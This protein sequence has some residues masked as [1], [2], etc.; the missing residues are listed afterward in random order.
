MNFLVWMGNH[1][2]TGQRSLE[3]VIGIFGH[4][5]R[6]LG[7]QIIWD[8]RNHQFLTAER[9]INIV[10]EGFTAGSL[11]ALEK[12]HKKNCRFIVL[13][14]EEPS[15]QGF[16]QG[17]QPEMVKRQQ[18]F[19]GVVRF[20]EAI[21]HLVPGEHVTRWYSQFLPTAQV[22]LGYAPTLIRKPLGHEPE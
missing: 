5:C 21:L 18:T 8:P 16:N 2:E 15:P 7:H 3:D 13:A 17:V 19:P 11:D 1:T 4:A 20:A 22:E 12:A 9:G 10:V 6:A 14:T